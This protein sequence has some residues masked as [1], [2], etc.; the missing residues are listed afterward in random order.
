M[1][2]PGLKVSST[3][4]FVSLFQMLATFPIFIGL[5]LTERLEQVKRISTEYTLTIEPLHCVLDI[6]F[7]RFQQL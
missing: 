2:E 5:L 7:E 3:M 1:F 4:E 6:L